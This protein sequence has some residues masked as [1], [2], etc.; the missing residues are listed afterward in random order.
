MALLQTELRISSPHHRF[1]SQ[2]AIFEAI[3]HFPDRI[4]TAHSFNNLL[5]IGATTSVSRAAQQS[6]KLKSSILAHYANNAS[7][8]ADNKSQERGFNHS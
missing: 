3:C 1:F 4:Y 2:K 8:L 6:G 5:I 7:R